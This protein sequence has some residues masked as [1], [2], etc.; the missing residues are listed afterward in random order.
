MSATVL[1]RLSALGDI[2][3][4]EPVPRVLKER[5]PERRI[6]YVTR[7]RFTAIPRGWPAVDQV[8]ALPDVIRGT[9]LAAL[10]RQLKA[11]GPLRR[12]DLHNTLRSRRLWPCGAA[13]LPKHRLQKWALVH[14][15]CL[16]ASWRHAALA[17]GPGPV[18]RRYLSL[19]GLP[20]APLEW[21]PRLVV[22]GQVLLYGECRHDLLVPGAGFATK[23]WPVERWLELLPLLLQQSATP[24]LVLGGERERPLGERLAALAPA[25]VDNLCGRTNLDETARLVAAARRIVTG[26]TGLLH[27]ADAAGVPGVALYGS[28]TR[29]LGF[30]PIDGGL[31]VLEHEL[32]C[33]PCSH[34]GRARCPLGHFACLAGI[35][36]AEVLERLLASEAAC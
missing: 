20:E 18:W 16:P 9:D 34:V 35:G 13:R 14:G 29:E 27:M 3:L 8:L 4:S 6:V 12:I 33:R 7:E 31:Q 24:V 15:K 2:L 25:R 5:E 23:A 1:L 21:R 30:Y 19:V 36:A 10:R 26:D 22:Q 32:P 28:T 11:L 17:G